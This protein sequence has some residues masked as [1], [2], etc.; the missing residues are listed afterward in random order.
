M[1]ALL[2]DLYAMIIMDENDDDMMTIPQTK[3]FIYFSYWWCPWSWPIH[4]FNLIRL[5]SFFCVI[6]ELKQ[7]KIYR[8]IVVISIFFCFLFSWFSCFLCSFCPCTCVECVCKATFVKI[9]MAKLLS[10][11]I[12]SDNFRMR[13]NA[14][15]PNS[16]T[17]DGGISKSCNYRNVYSDL[18]HVFR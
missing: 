16:G 14:F 1:C 10:I 8:R 11:W 9:E 5:N 6:S 4:M 13:E 18:L 17:V 3:L 12:L 7:F 15:A 2:A